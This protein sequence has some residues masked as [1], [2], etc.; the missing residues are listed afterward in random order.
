MRQ[1]ERVGD[2]L[3]ECLPERHL[4]EIDAD[5]V[6]DEICHLAAGYPCGDL[7][8]EHA[9]A[10]HEELRERDAV[11]QAERLRG[12]HRGA[13]RLLELVAEDRRRVHVDP[14]DTEADARRAEAVGERDD[15]GLAITHDHD[16]VQ[17]EPFV[18][19]LE[20]DLAARGFGERGMQVRLEVLDRVEAE[21]A[22]LPA[23]VG[24][25]Q[26][27]WEADGL[28]GRRG[29]AHRTRGGVLRL[30]HALFGEAPPHV[31]LVR[32]RVGDVGADSRQAER[33]RDCGDD[34][35]GAVGG[36]R[37]RAVDS[38][39]PSDLDHVVHILEVHDLADVGNLEPG[40]GAVPVDRHD[41]KPELPCAQDRAALV[42][43]CADEEDGLSAHRGELRGSNGVATR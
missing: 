18:K 17:L 8:H 6:A 25:L 26:D 35:H 34:R 22:A 28:R 29:V 5:G 30:R 23:R 3:S 37:Q 12:V 19:A 24:G 1:R 36:H 10:G 42:P 15:D 27:G 4:D 32:H 40:R 14:A 11:A 38:V 2:R 39:P 21:D 20:H 7:D 16:A 41:A 31:D 33:I 9:L 13:G 43:A